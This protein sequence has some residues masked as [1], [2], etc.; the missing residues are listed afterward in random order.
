M[1]IRREG[2]PKGL[3]LGLAFVKMAIEAHGGKVWVDPAQPHGAIFKFS[4]PVKN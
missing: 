3:G 4:L 1:R 2:G